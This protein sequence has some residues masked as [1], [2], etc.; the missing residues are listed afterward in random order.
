MSKSNYLEN[1]VLD[2][3]LGGSDYTRPGTVYVALFTA[4][5]S[6]TGGGTEVG[7]G[8]WTN[9]ARVSVTNNSTNWPAA[10]GGV[11]SNGAAISFGTAT[12]S[13]TS[14]TVTVVA[15]GIFDAS[16]SGNLLFWSALTVSK[17]VNHNDTISFP[18]SSITITED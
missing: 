15:M 9:Y 10:S 12:M 6:D 3:V 5:P 2:H 16:T 17:T 8:T 11:K 1:K 18:T 7:T 4:A 13:P 14:S